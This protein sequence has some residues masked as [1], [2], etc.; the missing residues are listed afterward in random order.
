MFVNIQQIQ[1]GVSNYI[2]NEL[3]K[4]AVGVQKFLVYFAMPIVNNNIVKIVNTYAENPLTK[5]MFDENH[6]VN[7]DMVY[8]M[9]KNG[10]QKSGQFIYLDI[11][12]NENDID[13]IYNYIKS[14]I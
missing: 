5:E 7:L 9:A 12:I 10:I 14:T 6:N 1:T 3:G 11:I 8:Q 13:K 4:K 2:D